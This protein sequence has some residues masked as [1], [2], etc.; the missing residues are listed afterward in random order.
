VRYALPTVLCVAFAA[1][2]GCEAA[3]RRLRV[4]AAAWGVPALVLVGG[5]LYARPILTARATSVSP[6][7]QAAVW[8]HQHLP[9]GTGILVQDD[10]APHAHSR[11]RGFDLSPVDSGLQSYARR[12]NMPLWLYAEGESTWPGAV[13]FRWPESDAYG[14]LTRNHYRIVSLS[15]IPA[16]ARYQIVRG[17]HPFEPSVRDARWRWLDSEAVLRIFPRKIRAIAVTLGLPIQAPL[18]FN[19]VI[20]SVN[21]KSVTTVQLPRGTESRVELPVAP[22]A[23]S[24]IAFHSSRSFALGGADSRHVAVQLRG[25]HRLPR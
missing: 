24:E 13:T 14:K 22:D 3:A 4:P 10:L 25:L 9:S 5:A 12:P 18:P 8:A 7:L 11:L 19:T 16:D 1:V 2:V 15:P 6:P 17:V 20:V 21:G 23:R